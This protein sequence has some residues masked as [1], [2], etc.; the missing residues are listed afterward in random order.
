MKFNILQVGVGG[1]GSYLTLPLK[2][3]L[4]SLIRSKTHTVKYILI[5]NDI[6]EEK[7]I[8]RQNFGIYDIGKY[9]CEIFKDYDYIQAISSKLNSNIFNILHM[10][11]RDGKINNTMNI[12]VGCVDNIQ[13]RLD[14]AKLLTSY[15]NLN[16]IHHPT[17]YIDS[18]NFIDTGQSYVF[19]YSKDTAENIESKINEIFNNDEF[20]KKMDMY[21]PSCTDNGDQSILANIQAATLLYSIITEIISYHTTSV[22]KISFCRYSRD[23][24]YDLKEQL[25]RGCI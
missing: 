9:K 1:T 10:L 21:S 16:C 11:L 15:F 12:V 20:A 2:K 18:G 22:K 14:I 8:Y 19:D 6:V 24:D 7:N 3:F 23:I 25:T 13:A 4:E 5:D 17:F